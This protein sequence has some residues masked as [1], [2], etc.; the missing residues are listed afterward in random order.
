[1]KS[2]GRA[3]AAA[4]L[5]GVW[6][7]LSAAHSLAAADRQ[8]HQ[9]P[10]LVKRAV[11]S[12]LSDD[13]AGGGRGLHV[14]PFFPRIE[15]VSSGAGLAP[16][17]HFWA[18]DI[19]GTRLDVH[20]S[21]AYSIYSYQYYDLQVG[22]VPHEGK[23]LPRVAWGTGGLFPLADLEKS[24]AAP[25]FDI[26]ASARYRDF[27]RED[28]Y[29]IGATS[30]RLDRT[31]YRMQDGLYEGIARV[32]VERLSI[33]A[34]AGL[35]QASIRPG[36]DSAFPG[37]DS[38]GLGSPETESPAPGGFRAMFTTNSSLRSGPSRL[39]TARSR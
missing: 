11:R 37:S 32:R 28:F 18:P 13:E 23:R 24:A 20:A 33:M 36:A 21:A 7:A 4:A 16:M 35:L 29:G 1:M 3:Q 39:R 5:A 12:F 25:G 2:R 15:I 14:G 17:V 6:I 19:G 34:R 8:E 9:R 22:R 27:P 10:S 38:A 26:Y 30:L 31:D